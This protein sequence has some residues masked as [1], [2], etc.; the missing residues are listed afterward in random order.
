MQ[1]FVCVFSSR[2][3][4]EDSPSMCMLTLWTVRFAETGSE[5]LALFSDS[6]RLRPDNEEKRKVKH[7]IWKVDFNQG[8]HIGSCGES[9]DCNHNVANRLYVQ[10][11]WGKFSMV[12]AER[13]LLA[14]ALKIPL[15]CISCYFLIGNLP[16]FLSICHFTH[17]KTLK[18]NE[19]CNRW[20]LLRYALC[21][22]WVAAVSHCVLS[23]TSMTI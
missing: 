23:T 11:V 14:N 20:M 15:T 17:G 10:A 12:D 1:W 6:L 2:D 3:M 4:K 5:A 22:A 13:R 19:Y 7:V 16:V 18:Q 9:V 21:L 8:G